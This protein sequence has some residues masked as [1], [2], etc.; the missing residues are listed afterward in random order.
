MKIYIIFF[1][2]TGNTA[3][4]IKQLSNELL[5][6]GHVIKIIPC[7]MENI[8]YKE[9]ESYDV[10]GIAY[11]TYASDAPSIIYDVISKLKNVDNKKAFAIT[12]MGYMSGD[13]NWYVTKK[14]KI[15]GYEPFLLCDIQ[16]GNNMH[17][18]YLSPLKVTN[19]E[20]LIKRKEKALKKIITIADKISDLKKYC[21]ST[22]IFDHLMGYSQRIGAKLFEKNAFKGFLVNDNCNKCG[23]C[24]KYCPNKNI[25]II[26]DN[27]IIGNNCMLCM[28]CYNYCHKKAIDST[29]KTQNHKKYKRYTGPENKIYPDI[30]KAPYYI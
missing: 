18:P 9:I 2:G 19:N 12:T 28:R 5:K 14:I 26:N 1:S 7:D 10:L 11:P 17:L 4:V 20:V 6:R 24:I 30:K 16:M 21:E 23:R 3:W 13:T 15:K 22:L 25:K 29:K 8:N 27:V